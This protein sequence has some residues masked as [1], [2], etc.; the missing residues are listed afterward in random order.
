MDRQ[1][2]RRHY[3]S[4]ATLALAWPAFRYSVTRD[5]YVLRFIGSSR[6]PVLR[7]NRRQTQRE[8]GGGERR[9]LAV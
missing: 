2:R 6:G 5:A 3:V 7:Q 8:H 1:E 9:R 4:R